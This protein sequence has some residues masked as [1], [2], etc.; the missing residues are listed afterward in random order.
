MLELHPLATAHTDNDL[1]VLDRRT[2]TLFA[3][4]VVFVDHL[5]V[6]DGSL[7]GWLRV[8]DQL[9]AIPARRVVPGHGPAALPWPAGGAAQR[10]YLRGLATAVRAALARGARLADVAGQ[11]GQN[12]RGTWRLFDD[13]HRRNVI[14]A[15]TELEW[16]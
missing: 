11:V 10:A 2:G 13:Y 14:A 16:E 6:I 1:V 7:L 8:A 12:L 15:F 4:D 5:P 3:G 9:A